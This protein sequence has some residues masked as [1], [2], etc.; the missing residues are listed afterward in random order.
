MLGALTDTPI[1]YKVMDDGFIAFVVQ[2]R[3]AEF[4]VK[5]V[6]AMAA[7]LKEHFGLESCVC[8]EC[9]DLMWVDV[10][11]LAEIK[12]SDVPKSLRDHFK[13]LEMGA[14]R[15]RTFAQTINEDGSDSESDEDESD[16]ESSST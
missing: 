10:D 11:A 8:G 12:D 6:E 7:A 2:S 3:P 16:S 15:K 14:G 1:I 13:K 5:A 4:K 9:E